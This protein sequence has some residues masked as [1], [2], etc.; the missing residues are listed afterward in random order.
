MTS[1]H[2]YREVRQSSGGDGDTRRSRTRNKGAA[3][4]MRLCSRSQQ[5]AERRVNEQRM[6]RRVYHYLCEAGGG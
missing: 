1:R 6:C 2:A 5:S 3:V 4:N